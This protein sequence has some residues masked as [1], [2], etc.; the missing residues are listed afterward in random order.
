MKDPEEHI[1]E[2]GAEV[3]KGT[4]FSKKKKKPL[5]GIS[6]I[7]PTQSI[8]GQIGARAANGKVAIMDRGASE[9]VVVTVESQE[10]K[11]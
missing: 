7:S 10:V 4:N 2:E 3:T 1:D 8:L 9:A 5:I 6:A 11:E